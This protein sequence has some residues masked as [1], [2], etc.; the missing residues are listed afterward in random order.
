MAASAAA[1]HAMEASR[2]GPCPLLL[3]LRCSTAR[4]Q[5]PWALETR[6][7]APPASTPPINPP[8]PSLPLLPPLPAGKLGKGGEPDLNTAAK[9]VL[10]DWQR[11]KIPFFTLPPGY[12]ED[13]P[14]GGAGAAA[15]AAAEEEDGEGLV[16]PSEAVTV[17]GD[18]GNGSAAWR[19]GGPVAWWHC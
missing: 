3:Q 14:P 13:A 11:G 4:L 16:L 19:G 15:A 18:G 6:G 12:S 2:A 5:C 10:Y 8:R 7:P 1:G 9:M 17:R